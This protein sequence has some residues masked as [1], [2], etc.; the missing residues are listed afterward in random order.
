MTPR[1]RGIGVATALIIAIAAALGLIGREPASSPAPPPGAVVPTPTAAGRVL[2]PTSA[3]TVRL[4]AVAAVLAR[5]ASAVLRHDRAA[6]LATVDPRQRSFWARQARLFEA[7]RVVPFGS[8]RYDLGPAAGNGQPVPRPSRYQASEVFAPAGVVL[9]YQIRG[10][11]GQP[12]ADS[13][14]LTFVR[15]AG[16]WLLASD[17][18]FDSGTV[19]T[20][21]NIWDNGPL[22]LARGVRTL[23]L[24]HPRPPLDLNRLAGLA[25]AAIPRVDAVWR[26][27]WSRRV[28]VVV[29]SSLAELASLL[30][31]P[32]ASLQRIAAV[33]TAEL[34]PGTAPV[35]SRV[36][37]N[38]VGFGQLGDLG[39]QLVLIHE[40]AHVATRPVTGEAAPSWL[41]EGFAD[42]VAYRD[43]GLPAGVAAGDLRR[44]VLAGRVPSG[45]PADARFAGTDPR[46]AVAYE[47]A[48]L[49]CRLIA[50]RSGEPA[51][52]R[53]YRLAAAGSPAGRAARVRTAFATA[54]RTTPTAF[55][56]AWRAYLRSTLG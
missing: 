13:Q 17:R 52:V 49:A 20:T 41:V 53:F 21:R 54:L 39:R 14:Q 46:L 3:A 43:T 12:A 29:P 5:R 11:D 34:Q 2:P 35:G 50:Q 32:A 56:V 4:Q 36:L 1:R 30:N 48:W 27:P 42:Y 15:R 7:L 8:W 23:V 55:T 33:A 10:F 38:P 51:L 16:R 31:R 40:V 6:F 44:E 22:V 26:V 19:R 24:A 25:D 9:R 37:I 28:V 45:L 47:E 18:D